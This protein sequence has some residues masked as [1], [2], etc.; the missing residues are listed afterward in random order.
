M[1]IFDI[2]LII[3]ATFVIIGICIHSAID[4]VNT[5]KNLQKEEYIRKKIEEYK[6][7]NFFDEN[8]NKPS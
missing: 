2:I 5:N 4:I 7:G 3:I 1:D 8:D 6:K